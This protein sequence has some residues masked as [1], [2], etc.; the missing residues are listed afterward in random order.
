M[1]SSLVPVGVCV[2]VCVRETGRESL[3]ELSDPSPPHHTNRPL[4]PLLTG[5]RG[6]TAL[7]LGYANLPPLSE[8][9]PGPPVCL[10]RG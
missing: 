7:G 8:Q 10:F 5:T 2:G 3:A 9:N 6:G 4:C 1:Q